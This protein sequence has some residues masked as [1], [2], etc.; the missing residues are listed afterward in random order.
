MEHPTQRWTVC[1]ECAG[2]GKKKQR[3][4]KSVRIRYEKALEEYEKSDGAIPE[5]VRPHA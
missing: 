5:P 2:Q 1:T 4:R 3:I